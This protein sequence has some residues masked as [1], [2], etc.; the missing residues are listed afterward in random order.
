M[1][2]SNYIKNYFDVERQQADSAARKTSTRRLWAATMTCLL[3]FA[4]FDFLFVFEQPVRVMAF[5]VFAVFVLWQLA[6]WMRA[7]VRQTS[8]KQVA[9][10]VEQQSGHETVVLTTAADDHVRNS[11]AEHELGTTMLERL[12]EHAKRLTLGVPVDFGRS[13]RNWKWAI[14][15]LCCVFLFFGVGGGFR[16][17]SRILIPWLQ[18]PYTRLELSGPGEKIPTL[19]TFQ[20]TGVLK[21]WRTTDV[22]LHRSFDD[23]VSPVVVREDRSF[24]IDLPGVSDDCTYWVTAGDGISNRI[25]VRTFSL[26]AIDAFQVS[27]TPPDYA[28]RLAKTEEQPNFEVLRGSSL[29]YQIQ[30]SKSVREVKLLPSPD[31]DVELPD[32]IHFSPTDDPLVYRARLTNLSKDLS[33]RIAIRDHKGDTSQNDE[34][35]RVLVMADEAPKL[36]I[37]GHD[38]KKVLKEGNEDVTVKVKAVDDVALVE[39]RLVYR[40]VGKSGA[41]ATLPIDGKKPFEFTA[42]SLLKFAPLE[43]E[44]L[45]VVVVHAEGVDGNVIDGPGIGK[46]QVV[47]IEVPEP[48]QEEQDSSGGG[49]GGG[50]QQVNPLEMQK[51]VLEDTSKLVGNEGAKAFDDIRQ[52]QEEVN[53]FVEALLTNVRAKSD[54]NPR[55]R[56]IAAQLELALST[57]RLSARQLGKVRR[58]ESLFAQEFA[59][60]TL[61]EAAKMMGGPT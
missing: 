44:P 31:G 60:A 12:D 55:A 20:L 11:L 37:T 53:G 46:S 45:D 48:P 10:H 51:Y 49:G 58:D 7:R 59:V 35:Y 2:T 52:E 57:M 29:D 40:K 32:P 4:V 33:Y 17:Y 14:L 13:A 56:G 6:A 15:A 24:S 19:S 42:A 43:L 18:L 54:V 27:V 36:K 61:T 39:M 26:T 25:D 3:L 41:T 38:A 1:S 50:G 34:P 21:G 5:G 22:Q 28:S 23:H 8:S 30:L 47:M 16:S 9:A